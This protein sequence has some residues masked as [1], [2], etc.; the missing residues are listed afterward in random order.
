MKRIRTAGARA[1]LV[2]VAGA[3]LLLAL[4]LSLGVSAQDPGW[5]RQIT[6]PSGKLVY[7]Q[8]QVDAWTNYQTLD[9]R[10]AFTITPTG[11]KTQVG[12]LTVQ[13]QTSVNMDT[14]TVVLSN[15]QITSVTFPSLD[16]AR[17]TQMD[18]LVRTYL[19]P[20]ATINISLDRL[21]A[22][23]KKSKTPPT[24]EVKNTPPTIFISMRPAILLQVRSEE[25]TS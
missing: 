3:V 14:H 8:P 22:S 10:L 23:V 16:R 11:G 1:Q 12:V 19:N 18:T 20:A 25:H 6:K 9:A 7:Y 5:P 4:G 13:L 17:S 2:V 24:T 21:V 15:P